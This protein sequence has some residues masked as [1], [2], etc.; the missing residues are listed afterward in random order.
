M[1]ARSE[2]RR[3]RRLVIH[4]RVQGVGYRAAFAAE[5]ERLGLIGWVRNRHE[6]T[7]EAL[8][9]GDAPA[10]EAI[11]AWARN[12][13]PLARVE[14]IETFDANAGDARELA[15]RDGFAVRATA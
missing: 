2:G 1:T 9:A 12:G 7:V 10:V 13:P 4:G 3:C 6:G 5:A 14:A 15:G 8:V 11:S